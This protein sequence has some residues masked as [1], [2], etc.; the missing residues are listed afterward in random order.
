MMNFLY[1][2]SR[3]FTFFMSNNMKILYWSLKFIAKRS[4]LRWQCPIS[5]SIINLELIFVTIS[6]HKE[7]FSS[8]IYI[9][10]TVSYCILIA[11]S[12]YSLIRYSFNCI[13]DILVLSLTYIWIGGPDI[14]KW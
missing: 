6:K 3:D 7:I 13:I 12:I 8:G 10:K 4:N 5:Q 1:F 9:T 11:S 2:R 14:C